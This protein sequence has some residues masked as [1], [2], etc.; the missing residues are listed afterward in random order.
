[1]ALLHYK[2]F[3]HILPNIKVQHVFAYGVYIQGNS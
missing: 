2:L 3:Q 1:M